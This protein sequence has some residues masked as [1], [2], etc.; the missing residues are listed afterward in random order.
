MQ[1]D[2]LG[3]TYRGK[4]SV[5][6]FSRYITQRSIHILA[7]CRYVKRNGIGAFQ[8]DKLTPEEYKELLEAMVFWGGLR[9]W[10]LFN[11]SLIAI[12]K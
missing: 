6:E 1:Q 4:L 10:A 2:K 9:V 7:H 11:Q 3:H 5:E 8:K 12:K